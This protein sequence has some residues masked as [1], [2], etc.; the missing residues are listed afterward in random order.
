MTPANLI[1]AQQSDS[2]ERLNLIAYF[3]DCE[4]LVD[5]FRE[6][7]QECENFMTMINLNDHACKSY[8][9]TL[10]AGSCVS[11]EAFGDAQKEITTTSG[12]FL[13]SLWVRIKNIFL[14]VYQTIKTFFRRL[15]D[16]N[17]R[18]RKKLIAL[19][20]DFAI[21]SSP[22][23][24]ERVENLTLTLVPYRYYT[25]MLDNLGTIYAKLT[26]IGMSGNVADVSEFNKQGF[27][28]FGIVVKNGEVFTNTSTMK[29]VPVMTNRLNY[30]GS[31]WGWGVDPI[32]KLMVGT[33]ALVEVLVEAEKLNINSTGL[34]NEC[35]AALRKIDQYSASGRVEDAI[36]TQ[37]ELYSL[38][39]RA[40]YVV[41]IN[42]LYQAYV[43][44]LCSIMFAA[45]TNVC[46]VK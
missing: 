40:N 19:M 16:V 31:D 10:L 37:D 46:A 18:N 27:D 17:I 8:I 30:T 7:Q 1:L 38:Q 11:E 23:I 25:E 39:R 22:A 2:A 21:K 9:N 36:R 4:K 44:Q 42:K 43:S 3:E 32:E 34:E 41:S 35:N 5:L 33:K 24:K 14:A 15:F 45:W 29:P 6:L 28:F 26:R 12:S 13:K 20:N